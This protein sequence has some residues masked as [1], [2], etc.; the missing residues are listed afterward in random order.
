MCIAWFFCGLGTIFCF[1]GVYLFHR[2]IHE[3]DRKILSPFLVMI[4]GVILIAIGTAKFVG[5]IR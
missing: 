5:L 2:K 3:K 4:M 1:T